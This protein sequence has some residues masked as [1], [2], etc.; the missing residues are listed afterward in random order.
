MANI[1]ILEKIFSLNTIEKYKI[2]IP[3]NININPPS[4][5]VFFL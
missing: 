4:L 5:G 1:I 3:F 2:I